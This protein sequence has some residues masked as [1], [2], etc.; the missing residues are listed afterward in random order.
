[1]LTNNQQELIEKLSKI[2]NLAEHLH[3]LLSET[4]SRLKQ[5]MEVKEAI[6]TLVKEKTQGFPW[7]A[8]AISQYYDFRDLKIAE[9]L[10]HKLR[11]AVSSAER[12]R[13][14]AGEKREFQRKFIITRNLIKYYEILFP[15]LTEFVG[16]DIDELLVQ[17]VQHGGSPDEVEDPVRTYLTPGEYDKLSPAERNQRALD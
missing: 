7:L 2:D 10:D 16:E 4:E 17:S 3:S 5:I 6:D 1:M 12:V 13:E 9:F 8:D 15:W 11:P 14:L